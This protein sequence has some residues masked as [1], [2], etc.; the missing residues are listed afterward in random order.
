MIEL[1]KEHPESFFA[2]V[3]VLIGQLVPITQ[4]IASG[5]KNIIKIFFELRKEKQK[6]IF[7][8]LD[9]HFKIF[10]RSIYAKGDLL[11]RVSVKDNPNVYQLDVDIGI[12]DFFGNLFIHAVRIY[13]Y[14]KDREK[15]KNY[16]AY[17]ISRMIFGESPLINGDFIVED[18]VNEIIS[19]KKLYTKYLKMGQNSGKI[20]KI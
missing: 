7:N 12:K 4:L 19:H 8:A 11:C 20:I 13:N 1:F 18:I 3:G 17:E 10:L 5:L 6:T 14:T 16:V 15:C 2:L 9:S